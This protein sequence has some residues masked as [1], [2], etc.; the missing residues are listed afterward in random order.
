MSESPGFFKAKFEGVAGLEPTAEAVLEKCKEGHKPM[1]QTGSGWRAWPDN[2]F[3]KDVLHWFAGL[4]SQIAEFANEHQFMRKTS[5]RPLAQLDQPLQ[6]STAERKL[7]I[8]FVD[9][10]KAGEDSKCHWSQ[11]LVPGE[12]KRN[13]LADIASEGMA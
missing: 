9:D 2:A 6:G 13:P 1:H 8:G 11:I 5:R 10:S 3:E 4:S 7:D 12:L